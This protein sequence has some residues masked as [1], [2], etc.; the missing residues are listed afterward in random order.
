MIALMKIS[1]RLKKR[2]CLTNQRLFCTLA[3]KYTIV[4]SGLL[5][6]FAVGFGFYATTKDYLLVSSCFIRMYRIVLTAR[7]LSN[8]WSL[9]LG[10]FFSFNSNF[11]HL[12]FVHL[13]DMEQTCLCVLGRIMLSRLIIDSIWHSHSGMAVC[14]LCQWVPV[15]LY[16]CVCISAGWVGFR[17]HQS[18][19]TGPLCTKSLSATL[20]RCHVGIARI[21]KTFDLTFSPPLHSS[22]GKKTRRE[23]QWDHSKNTRLVFLHSDFC[24]SSQ[25]SGNKR[26]GESE[27]VFDA[28]HKGEVDLG[29][30]PTED[31]KDV[32]VEQERKSPEKGSPR[33]RIPRL[34]LHPFRP[35]DKG[36][37]L[38]DS[39]FSEEE[40]KECDMSSDHSK[41]TISSNSFCSGETFVSRLETAVNITTDNFQWVNIK[42]F[43]VADSL[44]G[45][46]FTE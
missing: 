46:Y 39:P 12:I 8:I 25:L 19:N 34:V 38:S 45:K 26:G 41:R 13:S 43:K 28:C 24:M 22:G 18:S 32:C 15:C 29:C 21:N 20:K 14:Q 37:P 4:F 33:S 30:C 27:N 17:R 23:A 40:G 10:I 6:W 2:V 35:K 5:W 3:L 7:I 9:K 1:L 11:F 31:Q 36:S 44:D 42:W 16:V